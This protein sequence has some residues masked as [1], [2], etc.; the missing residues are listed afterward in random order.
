MQS[1]SEAC[2]AYLGSLG[3]AIRQYKQTANYAIQASNSS[4]K[5]PLCVLSTCEML[6]CSQVSPTPRL[7]LR[8]LSHTA[9]G[10]AC[11]DALWLPYR[12]DRAQL[13][14]A[15]E[16]AGDIKAVFAHADVVRS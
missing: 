3:K 10:D 13:K 2:I 14:E 9:L 7:C 5:C 11:R 16:G 6:K 12:K 1:M 4:S 15:I 8:A